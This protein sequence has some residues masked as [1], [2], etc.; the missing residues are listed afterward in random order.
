[1]AGKRESNDNMNQNIKNI[2]TKIRDEGPKIS[3]GT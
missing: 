1:V 2:S 3:V